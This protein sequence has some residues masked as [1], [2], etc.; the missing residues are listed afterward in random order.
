MTD[1]EYRE[2]KKRVAALIDKWAKPLEL[3]RWTITYHWFREPF[4]DRPG[5]AMRV[6]TQWEYRRADIEISVPLLSEMDDNHLENYL[7]HEY[8]HILL[9]EMCDFR[10]CD[11][12]AFRL[13][14]ESM[15][16][17]FANIFQRVK[18]LEQI[19]KRKER[20]A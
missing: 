1:K 18:V 11:D 2:Q 19:K 5:V 7:L 15:A 17:K 4:S 16:T 14:D 6:E 10:H 9:Q 12:A 20:A 8:S 3:D 13:I